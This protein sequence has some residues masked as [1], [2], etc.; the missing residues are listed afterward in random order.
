MTC[1]AI[2][3]WVEDCWHNTYQNAPTDNRA[4]IHANNGDCA[5]RIIRG[6]AWNDAAPALRVLWQTGQP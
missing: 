6:G 1:T 2:T 5:F 4:C 3:E